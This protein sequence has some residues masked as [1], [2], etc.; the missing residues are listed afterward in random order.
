MATKT[1]QPNSKTEQR[2]QT[3]LNLDTAAIQRLE[4]LAAAQGTTIHSI[5]NAA[6]TAYQPEPE[7]E[8]IEAKIALLEQLTNDFWASRGPMARYTKHK[9]G[10]LEHDVYAFVIGEICPRTRYTITEAIRDVN[11]FKPAKPFVWW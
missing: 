2:K 1:N 9:N 6:I 3:R 5:S 4:T 7:T 8:S 10:I 11:S